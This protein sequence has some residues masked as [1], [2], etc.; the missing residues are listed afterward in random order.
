MQEAH[1][2]DNDAMTSI[3]KVAICEQLGVQ[4]DKSLLALLAQ[5]LKRTV[6]DTDHINTLEQ[7]KKHALS[8]LVRHNAGN[9]WGQQNCA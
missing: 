9:L 2:E 4:G 1:T 6:K 7:R 8:V 3:G 5:Y